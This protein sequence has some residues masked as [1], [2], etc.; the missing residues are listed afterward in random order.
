MWLVLVILIKR[1]HKYVTTLSIYLPGII[2]FP[3]SSSEI[4]LGILITAKPLKHIQEQ[5]EKLVIPTIYIMGEKT[6]R[7]EDRGKDN[8]YR[9]CTKR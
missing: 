2:R 7:M 3:L 9:F 6:R 8:V 5:I 1:K 4:V